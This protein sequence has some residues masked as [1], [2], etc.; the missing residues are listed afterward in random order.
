MLTLVRK[1]VSINSILFDPEPQEGPISGVSMYS[2]A[3]GKILMCAL[4]NKLNI[5]CTHNFYER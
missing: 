2:G 4:S 3:H 5:R 1:H